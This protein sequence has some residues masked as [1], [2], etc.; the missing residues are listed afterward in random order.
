MENQ[1][2][3]KVNH[4]GRP[5]K[6]LGGPLSIG[7]IINRCLPRLRVKPSVSEQLSVGLILFLIYCLFLGLRS[8][9]T[10]QPSV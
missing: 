3:T 4:I 9:S 10:K 6:R 7:T 8:Q 2:I 5:A 1:S